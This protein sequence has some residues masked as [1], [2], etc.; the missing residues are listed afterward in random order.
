MLKLTEDNTD[1]RENDQL[2]YYQEGKVSA[3]R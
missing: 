3:N 2:R 1:E